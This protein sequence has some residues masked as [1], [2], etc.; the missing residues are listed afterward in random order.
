LGNTKPAKLASAFSPTALVEELHQV[1]LCLVSR[2]KLRRVWRERLFMTGRHH[3]RANPGDRRNRLR[4][5]MVVLR[6]N[7]TFD[8]TL[9]DRDRLRRMVLLAE[10]RELKP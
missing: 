1:A 2:P 9:P 8:I 10:P 7:R 6:I 3:Q 4:I 5:G